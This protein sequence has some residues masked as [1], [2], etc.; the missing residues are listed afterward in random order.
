[1]PWYDPELDGWDDFDP[2][3]DNYDPAEW[4]DVP[5]DQDAPMDVC[6]FMRLVNG[7]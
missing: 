3:N 1:M 5:Y 6:T 4:S 2:A 7:D